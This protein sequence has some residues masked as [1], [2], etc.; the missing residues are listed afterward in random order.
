MTVDLAPLLDLEQ[1]LAFLR[2]Q[3]L[4]QRFWR[5]DYGRGRSLELFEANLRQRRQQ[6]LGVIAQLGFEENVCSGQD[7]DAGGGDDPPRHVAHDRVARVL[8]ALPTLRQRRRHG[9]AHF[10][11]ALV[12]IVLQ[13]VALQWSLRVE[14]E[15][16]SKAEA[17]ARVRISSRP[18]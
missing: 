12:Q 6:W 18:A 2:R 8:H 11:D 13:P 10:A 5:H 15:L 9:S 1:I 7:R 4:F 3:Q 17:Q 16:A 14:R